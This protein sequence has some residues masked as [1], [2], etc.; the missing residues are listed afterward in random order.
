MKRLL[1]V[2]LIACTFFCFTG[3]AQVTGTITDPENTPLPG[4]SIVIMGSTTGTTSDFD[5]KYS[6]NASEGDVLQF[7]YVGMTTVTRTVGESDIIDIVL[8]EDAEALDEVVVTALGIEREKKA[9]GYAS[10]Q[11]N[12]DQL[13]EV[14]E[15]NVVSALS[16]KI[17]GA[18]ISTQGGAPGQGARIVLRG[19]NSLDPNAENQPLFVIDGIPVS[20]DSYTTGGGESRGMTNRAG[21]INMEDVQNISVLKGGAATALYGVRGANG[22]VIITTRKGKAGRTEFNISAS[23]SF[24]EVN[25]FPK[26]QKTYT[27]GWKG[28]YDPNSFWP[29]WGPSV[30]EARKID[31]SHP[32]LFNNYKNA[33]KNGHSTNINFSASG[34]TEK[35][36]FYAALSKFDQEGVIPFSDY[37]KISAKLSGDLQLSDKIKITGSANFINS[38]GARVNIDRF[39]TRLIYWAPRVDVNDYEFEN[40]TMKGYQFDG[41]EGN[42]SIYGAKTNRFVDDVNRL[43]GNLGFNY[44]PVEGLDISYRFGI[45]YYNDSR[46]ATAP[47][48]REDVEDENIFGDNELGHII[49][50][51]IISEDLT[52]NLMA[53]YIRDLGEDFTLT[54]R[55][56][57][58]VFQR[59]YDRVTTSGEELDVWNLFHLSNA[60]NITTSQFISKFRVVGLYGEVGISYKDFLYL[61]VTDRNDWA[62]TLPEKNRSFNYPSVSGSYVFTETMDMPQWFNYGKVRASWAQI[63][64]DPQIAYLTSDVYQSDEDNFPIENVTGW[65]RPENKADPD[66]LSEKTTEIEFGT[67]LRFFDNRLSLDVSWYQSNAKDQIIRIPLPF[68]TGYKFY[69]TNAGEIENTGWEIMLNATPVQSGDFSWNVGVNFS[70]NKNEIVALKEGIESVFLDSEFGYV[71]SDASQVLYAGHAYGNILGTSYA[72]YYENPG[73]EDPLVVDKNRPIL[74]GEDGF[75]VIDRGQKIIGNSTPDWM[76]NIRNQVN[77]KNFSLAFN[78]DFRQGLEKFNNLGNFLSAFGT[79]DYTTNRNETIVFEGVTADGSP[80]TKE[81]Y[82]GQGIGPDGEDYGDGFYRNVHRA[83]TENFV[84]DA[85]W[86]RLKDV[87]LTYNFPNAILEKLSIARA[88]ISLSGTNLWLSTDYSGFDP[89]TSARIG[90]ADGFAGMG[91]FPGLRSYAATLRLTF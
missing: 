74:I 29:T 31:P 86:V 5:G 17:A 64:K 59:K 43:I 82:L 67:E 6:I 57:W 33:Y 46:K 83:V 45:D 28:E 54:V 88:S 30:E 11:L 22:V 87:T 52:S 18:Q 90:N 60:A 7:S 35:S 89:E 72:R 70:N 53:S 91:S 36:T 23:T 78:F 8:E 58:D 75:P 80:N 14:P 71:G 66:L 48:P 68:S 61:T 24:D 85:S 55:A 81:V 20:N 42:N 12:S 16:G 1:L 10:Q 56:G 47:G 34:G 37:G 26:T 84:E 13:L 39:N 4:V 50:T 40:G 27:Q 21:D 9:L 32:D 38:G 15:T 51:R 19:V 25:K 65:T 44:T 76:M 79:A 41:K 2:T 73:D 62:S 49:E 69:S 3:Y 77:Y 63:G